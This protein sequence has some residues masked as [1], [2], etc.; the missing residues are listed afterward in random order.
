MGKKTYT[1][2]WSITFVVI[3]IQRL[4]NIY[5]DEFPSFTTYWMVVCVLSLLSVG[6]GAWGHFLRTKSKI[7]IGLVWW[8]SVVVFALTYYFTAVSKHVGLS[9]SLYVYHN[10]VVLFVVGVVIFNYRDKILP[11]ELGASVS[12][13][14]LGVFQF[15]AATFAL[16]QGEQLNDFYRELY[17]YLNLVTMPAAFTA[18]G[19]F[20]IFM[21]A[22]DLSEEMKILA[23]TDSLTHTLNRRGFFES[24]E[25]STNKLLGRA[26]HIAVVLWDIDKFKSVNDRFGHA[27][28]DKVLIEIVKLIEP[29]LDQEDL[30][31]RMGGEE[32]VLLLNRSEKENTRKAI[33]TIRKA[34]ENSDI[35]FGPKQIN[36]TASFGAVFLESESASIEKAIDI[37]DNALYR[38]KK[39]GRNRVVFV[40]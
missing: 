30:L 11:A 29:Y 1:L 25:K 37:A 5:I 17:T 13:I 4:F 22:S 39:D 15:A 33:E 16:L 6:F 40:N 2:L 8:T 27:A 35:H 9:M 36:V 19:L 20:V 18:M 34:I 12:Y 28:G 31:A 32:F 26:Q 7:N 14:M 21:L 3:V 24:V 38:A 10:A 23:M